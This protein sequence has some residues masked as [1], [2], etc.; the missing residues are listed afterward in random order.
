MTLIIDRNTSEGK[1]K[2]ETI[3]WAEE[4]VNRVLTQIFNRYRLM[5]G[6]II[7]FDIPLE[8]REDASIGINVTEDTPK[9]S[10]EFDKAIE[11]VS[12]GKAVELK[13]TMGEIK[14]GIN[15]K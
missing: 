2:I 3:R 12:K 9:N 11:E 4:Q 6:L 7:K 15:Q 1:V 10:E 8:S 13:P 5:K 14:D